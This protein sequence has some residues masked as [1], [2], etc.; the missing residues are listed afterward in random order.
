M[1]H[2]YEIYF[3]AYQKITKFKNRPLIFDAQQE[4]IFVKNI[5]SMY[6]SAVVE[7]VDDWPSLSGT[8]VDGLKI[9]IVLKLLNY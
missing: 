8:L 6:D 9:I 7:T 5:Y 4:E 2:T 3:I 1:W